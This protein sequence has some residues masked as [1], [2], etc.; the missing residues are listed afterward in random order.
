MKTAI[1]ESG[2]VAESGTRTSRSATPQM[3][4]PRYAP[5]LENNPIRQ[6]QQTKIHMRQII[7]NLEE[8]EGNVTE[9]KAKALFDNSVEMLTQLVRAF[10]DYENEFKRRGELNS[11]RRS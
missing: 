7:N 8:D 3:F 1:L 4:R 2:A 11:S 5:P 10:D 6:M 9:A